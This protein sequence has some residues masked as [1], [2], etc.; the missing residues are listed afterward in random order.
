M[1]K[2]MLVIDDY[3]ELVFVENLLKRMGF[4]VLSLNRDTTFSESILSFFPELLIATLK[5]RHVEGLRIGLLLKKK[6][7]N[8]K[9][10][11]L[12]PS[13]NELKLP[14]EARVDALMEVPVE[15]LSLL[16][17][18]ARLLK[19]NEAQLIEKFEKVGK[20]RNFS[21]EGD[22]KVVKDEEAGSG[23]RMIKG[24]P[25]PAKPL[26]PRE[27]R[28]EE[29]LAKMEQSSTAQVLPHV[30]I[31]KR[32]Q[33]ARDADKDN[34]ELENKLTEQKRAFVKALMKSRKGSAQ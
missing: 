29:F 20:A 15:A 10:V 16:K 18:I 21:R 19:M 24:G 34:A 17:E 27:K 22:I 26:S 5:G 2:V 1:A 13:A 33:E 9:V 25:A 4:D 8:S 31:A 23:N 12:A 32:A 7:P 11:M 28:Y 30:E 3:S 14:P 6:N